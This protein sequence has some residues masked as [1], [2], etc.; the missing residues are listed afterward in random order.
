M[1][2]N[3]SAPSCLV[4][5]RGVGVGCRVEGDAGAVAEADASSMVASGVWKVE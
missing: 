2:W 1:R 3:Q 5:K 4:V